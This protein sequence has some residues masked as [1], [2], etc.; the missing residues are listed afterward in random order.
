MVLSSPRGSG[1]LG[2]VS[3]AVVAAGGACGMAWCLRVRRRVLFSGGP[4]LA[5]M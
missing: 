2:W 4:R 3:V 5:L 1:C